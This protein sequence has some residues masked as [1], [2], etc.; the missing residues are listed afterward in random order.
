M[1]K[2]QEESCQL[3]SA[4]SK[5]SATL[6]KHKYFLHASCFPSSPVFINHLMLVPLAFAAQAAEVAN[7]PE[8]MDKSA[9]EGNLPTYFEQL[10]SRHLV[11]SLTGSCTACGCLQEQSG[12]HMVTSKPFLSFKVEKINQRFFYLM[13]TIYSDNVEQRLASW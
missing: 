4:K 3:S 5:S 6:E 2:H 12:L 13:T 7:E 10:H 9:I 1:N 11:R 8:K